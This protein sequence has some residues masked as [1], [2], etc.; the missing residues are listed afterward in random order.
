MTLVL[1]QKI[2]REHLIEGEEKAGE[3]I[4]IRMDQIL[5]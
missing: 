2:L 5:T 1:T 4:A 3:E